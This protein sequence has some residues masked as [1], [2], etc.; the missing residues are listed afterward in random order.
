M[1]AHLIFS[2]RHVSRPGPINSH[3][4]PNEIA[5]KCRLILS[6]ASDM[7]V[8]QPIDAYETNSI[9]HLSVAES[10]AV[11]YFSSTARSP[12]PVAQG[13]MHSKH[14]GG[15]QLSISQCYRQDNNSSCRFVLISE[16]E[17]TTRVK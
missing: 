10:K 15:L 12:F 3:D 1:P 16:E 13:T 17:N 4:I 6:S 2:Q 9:S 11:C 5:S 8:D 7:S 14:M